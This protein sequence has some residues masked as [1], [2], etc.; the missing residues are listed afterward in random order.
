MKKEMYLLVCLVLV[1]VFGLGYYVDC[2]FF[3]GNLSYYLEKRFDNYRLPPDQSWNQLRADQMLQ[4]GNTEKAVRAYHR[5]VK[6]GAP[7]EWKDR[8]AAELT[9]RTGSSDH[10]INEVVPY[11]DKM[12][13]T[14]IRNHKNAFIAFARAFWE[15]VFEVYEKFPSRHALASRLETCLGPETVIWNAAI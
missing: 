2:R 14:I 6:D 8:F 13:N 10:F 7:R 9:L 15:K 11:P 3:D 1:F 4:R 12:A 5:A